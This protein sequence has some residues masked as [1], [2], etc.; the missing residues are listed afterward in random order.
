MNNAEATNETVL[1]I[2]TLVF[3][4]S[5]YYLSNLPS[6]FK[7]SILVI[8]NATTMMEII[9]FCCI[10]VRNW[11]FAVVMQLGSCVYCYN[12]TRN[13]RYLSLLYDF[14]VI[15]AALARTHGQY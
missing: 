8:V 4:F 12:I 6:F 13:N 1:V 9:S 2:I 11:R 3:A 5:M 10:S 14:L 7:K 15:F